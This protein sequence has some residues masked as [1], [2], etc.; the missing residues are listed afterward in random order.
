MIKDSIK[1]YLGKVNEELS[2]LEEGR[3]TGNVEFKF[4]IK[5]GGIANINVRLNKSIK[6]PNEVG[7]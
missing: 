7:G 3:F 2:K 6:K 4:N 5:D 1:Y